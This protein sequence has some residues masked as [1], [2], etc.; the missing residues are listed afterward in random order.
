[1]SITSLQFA[2]FLILVLGAYY[3]LPRRWQNYLLLLASYGFYAS[4]SWHFPVVLLLATVLTYLLAR[5]LLARPGR[6]CLWAGIG[7]NILI[8]VVFKYA[9][10]YLPNLLHLIGVGAGTPLAGV[11]AIALPVGFSYRVLENISFLVDAY[12]GEVAP[13]PGPVE[14]ALYTA[15]FP[16]L[17]SGPI[18][19]GRTFIGQLTQGRLVDNEMLSRGFTLI[20]VGAVRKLVIADTIRR[21]MPA[22]VFTT[23]LEYPASELAFWLIAE[24]FVI[25]NDFAGYID[26]I[27]GISRLFGIELSRNFSAPFF[28]RNFTELWMRWHM[29]LSF[30]LRDYVYM[31]ITRAVLRRSANPVTF[32]TVVVPPLAAMIVSALWHQAAWHM[33]VWGLLWGIF[34]ILG[35]LPGMWRTV[36]PADRLPLRHQFLG[37]M[38]V[39][40]MLAFSTIPFVMDLATS[41]DFCRGLL[42]WNQWT[43]PNLAASVLVGFSLAIDGFQHRCKDEAVFH[44]WPI[45]W[46]SAVLAGA[47]IAIFLA[48]RFKIAEPFIYQGF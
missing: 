9:D 31:P 30:W 12:R 17:L 47:L 26:I 4:W 13:L 28:S 2:G 25:Y 48:T 42:R 15:Y 19:R 5:R 41:A 32:N 39:I 16:K 6:G 27:R 35:R 20:V 44:R 18:E 23:P 29:T 24:V 40:V 8:L 3:L 11:L 45:L 37:M 7:L 46:R 38:R 10:F 33:L 1:M 36:T 34:L 22:G 14:F 21:L 43:M